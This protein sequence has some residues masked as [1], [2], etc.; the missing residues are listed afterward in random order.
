VIIGLKQT[1]LSLFLYSNYIL[2]MR[3]CALLALGGIQLYALSF[4]FGSVQFVSDELRS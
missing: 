3:A 4:G 2:G 1:S